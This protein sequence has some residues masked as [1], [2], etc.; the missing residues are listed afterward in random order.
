MEKLTL[1]TRKKFPASSFHSIPKT[2]EPPIMLL[3]SNFKIFKHSIDENSL[4]LTP[5]ISNRKRSNSPNLEEL[6]QFR[7]QGAVLNQFDFRPGKP[8]TKQTLVYPKPKTPFTSSIFEIDTKLKSKTK[9]SAE[10]MVEPPNSNLE[11]KPYESRIRIYHDFTKLKQLSDKNNL[12]KQEIINYNNQFSRKGSRTAGFLK[13]FQS[14]PAFPS[15]ISQSSTFSNNILQT[16][17]P[18]LNAKKKILR[19][20]NPASMKER[21]MIRFNDHF[22]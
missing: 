19:K 8:R 4:Y 21:K 12:L 6:K 22:M 15:I 9:R 2:D 16:N 14:C 18:A 20:F 17:S 5:K 13:N 10:V 1:V 11:S 3:S 7:F